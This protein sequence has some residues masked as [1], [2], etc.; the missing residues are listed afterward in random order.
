MSDQD[1]NG[2]T[3]AA[4]GSAVIEGLL[5]AAAYP[6]VVG[7]LRL[8]ET[9][10]SWVILTGRY[11]YKLK[12]PVR[13]EFLDFS[14]LALRKHFCEEE[15]R[16][17]RRLAPELYEDVVAIGGSER[18]PRSGQAPVFE[19]A[20]RMREFP[21]DAQLDRRLDAGALSCAEMYAL[22]ARIAC[23]HLEAEPAGAGSAYGDAAEVER[24]AMANFEVLLELARDDTAQDALRRLARWT[25]ARNAALRETFARR[26]S[27]GWIREGHGDLHLAN[28][29]SLD[30]GI[31]AFDCLEFDPRL[32]WIDVMCDVAFL[33]MDLEVRG[34]PDLAYAFLD[35]YL[36]TTGDYAG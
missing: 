17:N 20:L 33:V 23:F 4:A 3:P 1:A 30:S 35:A 10:I 26:K 5:R 2:T 29:V 28:L 25:E 11:A 27:E 7:P 21:A 12:K 24:A 8:I 19:S 34:R 6:H 15:L 36:E 32:R 9:H 18:E 14:T 13:L 22:G 31:T 16:L